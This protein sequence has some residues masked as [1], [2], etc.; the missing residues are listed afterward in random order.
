MWDIHRPLSYPF[1]FLMRERWMYTM[2]REEKTQCEIVAYFL[3]N[4]QNIQLQVPS[5]QLCIG[6]RVCC[7][8]GYGLQITKKG[9]NS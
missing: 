3:K 4:P 9:N 1:R 6:L 5:Q 2:M 7:P 8:L